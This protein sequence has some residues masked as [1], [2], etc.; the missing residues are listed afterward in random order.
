[1]RGEVWRLLTAGLLHANFVHLFFNVSF[2][3]SV[4][5]SAENTFGRSRVVAILTAGIVFG[6]AA[7]TLFTT[8]PSVGISGGL[9]ALLG[10]LIV[11]G[12]RNRAVLP[13][14]LQ[15]SLTKPML[16]TLGVSL[17]FG[18]VAPFIDNAAHLG[19]LAAGI[20]LG[21]ILRASDSTQQPR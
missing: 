9:F 21:L 17:V 10:A 2:L 7:S 3:L 5:T 18:A 12:I 15:S 19:G 6:F 4:G 8:K 13:A 14:S 11:F 20:T 16:A 1:M